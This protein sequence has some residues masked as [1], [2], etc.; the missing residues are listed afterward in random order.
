MEIRPVRT[1]Q[2]R[3]A[4]N[5]PRMKKPNHTS[6]REHWRRII[7]EADTPVG[8]AFDVCLI[9]CILLSVLVV[10][11]ASV[12]EF[13]EAHATGL[14]AA[15]WFFT[16]LF[17]VEYA[18]RLWTTESPLRYAR[19]FF[20]VVDVLAILPTYLSLFVPGAE[21]F[22]IVRALR[23]LRVFRV[24]KLVEYLREARTIMQALKASSRKIQV[25][26][27]AVAILVVIFGS[28]MYLVEG[29][30]NGFTSIPRGI[31]WAVVTISTVGYGDVTPQ[32]TLGQFLASILMVTGYGIIAV[33]TG[34]VTAE[35]TR[36][37][38]HT[39]RKSCPHCSAEGH[40][41]DAVFCRR[42]GNPMPG[43]DA[44]G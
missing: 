35:F 38:I 4:R 22:I 36:S 28:L 27:L 16:I 42:C 31:Y 25:F 29:E 3:L 23:V 6:L 40:A 33:P 7:F 15:E 8:R 43:T 24:L 21:Y 26:L 9:G 41:E 1:N 19:S 12:R 30:A 10:M 32:T 44:S 39:S 34:I 18:A 17:T 5:E 13:R 37:Y 14:V 2:C 11:L 20:G